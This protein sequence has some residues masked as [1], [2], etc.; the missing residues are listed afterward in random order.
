[1]NDKNNRDEMYNKT[2]MKV[3]DIEYYLR[4]A[5]TS[6]IRDVSDTAIYGIDKIKS[7]LFY[8]SMNLHLKKAHEN[9]NMEF[10]DSH[11]RFYRSYFKLI[12]N[13]IY[14][15][16]SPHEC[17]YDYFLKMA[18]MVERGPVTSALDCMIDLMKDQGEDIHPFVLEAKDELYQLYESCY[19]CHFEALIE[20]ALFAYLE[21]KQYS[22]NYDQYGFE[23]IAL[24]D[25]YENVPMIQQMYEDNFYDDDLEE[26]WDTEKVK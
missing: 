18:G 21:E 15:H 12:I 26:E 19:S 7:N 8:E 9:K 22:L 17:R 5:F 25:I 3:K 20:E 23:L 2:L 24:R 13:L 6:F 4:G 14:V 10:T 11:E 1:M 16:Y